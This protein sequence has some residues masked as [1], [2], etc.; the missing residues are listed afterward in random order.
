MRWLILLAAAVSTLSVTACARE[1][2]D[3]AVLPTALEAADEGVAPTDVEA[4]IT[5][6]ERDWVAAIVKR[7]TAALD[8]LL[9]SDFSGTSPSAYTYTKTVAI[10]EVADS[11][12]VVESMD[13][14][15]VSVNVYGDAAVAFTSQ[16]DRSR[17]DGK[18]TS[19]HY[20]YT[21]VWVN[22]DGRWQ[23]VASHGTKFEIADF[24]EPE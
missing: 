15:E 7:D 5:Q 11:K 20:H 19:G 23:V 2:V 9:A 13:L 21:N 14:D 4:A 24:H 18:D 3:E 8:R 10:S 12:F 17:Y 16:Q 6:L 22:R 1:A